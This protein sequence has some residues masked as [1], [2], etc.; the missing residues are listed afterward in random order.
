MVALSGTTNSFPSSGWMFASPPCKAGFGM[1]GFWVGRLLCG[2]RES[3]RG[4]IS[5]QCAPA[6]LQ[7]TFRRPA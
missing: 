3:V 5:L 1:F 7:G 2:R 4:D 6:S